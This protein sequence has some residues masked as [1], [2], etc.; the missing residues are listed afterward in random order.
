MTDTPV[1]LKDNV[2]FDCGP[3]SGSADIVVTDPYFP[4]CVFPV[5]VIAHTPVGTR[6]IPS[7][8]IKGNGEI[9]ES[10]VGIDV[11]ISISDWHCDSK[12]VTCH[13]KA[14][15]K[16]FFMSCIVIDKDYQIERHNPQVFE[17]AIADFHARL[18]ALDGAE[19][20]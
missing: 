20:S 2:P 19:N 10:V 18:E 1:I 15:A 8:E 16:K 4:N 5:Q 6:A 7:F 12:T 3:I 9:K 11:E 17:V 13:V 14:V